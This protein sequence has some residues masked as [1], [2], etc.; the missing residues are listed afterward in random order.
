M[1]KFTS[2]LGLI[3]SLLLVLFLASCGTNSAKSQK[4]REEILKEIMSNK[5]KLPFNIPGTSISITDIA[6]DND[7]IAYT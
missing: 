6:I 2:S 4:E 3:A 7:I 1:G 5:D